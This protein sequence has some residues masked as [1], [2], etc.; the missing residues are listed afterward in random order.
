MFVVIIDINVLCV[1]QIF[2]VLIHIVDLVNLVDLLIN[3]FIK[4]MQLVSK[5]KQ[6]KKKRK[7]KILK[8][9]MKKVMTKRNTDINP[10]LV[11][12]EFHI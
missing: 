8:K 1:C 10:I 9:E 4:T 6:K 11:S 2:V 5:R 3:G 12:I 7:M